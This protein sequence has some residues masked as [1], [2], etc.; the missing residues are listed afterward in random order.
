M[1]I[2]KSCK[3]HASMWWAQAVANWQYSTLVS[4]LQVA[5]YHGR[6]ITLQYNGVFQSSSYGPFANWF[7]AIPKQRSGCIRAIGADGA[8]QDGFERWTISMCQG[9]V[10]SA[11]WVRS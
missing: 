6:R 11:R 2:S 7:A 5:A 3:L 8:R 10:L 4:V 9:V 1:D